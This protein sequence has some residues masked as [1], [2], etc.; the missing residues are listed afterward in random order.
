[1]VK[2]IEFGSHCD[3][4]ENKMVKKSRFKNLN[5]T[6]GYLTLDTKKTFI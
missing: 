4:C 6:M 5:K 3:D 2:N 1:M